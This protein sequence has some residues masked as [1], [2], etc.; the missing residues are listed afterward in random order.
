MS[1]GVGSKLGPYEILSLAGA[2]GMGEVYRA[3]DSRL[4]RTVAVKILPEDVAGDKDR[5]RRF[6]QE[7]RA[8]AALNHPN[9]LSIHDTGALDGTRYIV[10]ELL[11]GETLRERLAGGPLPVRKAV[12]YALQICRGLAA[13][14]EKGITHRDLKPENV[15]ITRDG[16]VKILDFGLAKQETAAAAAATAMH[17]APVDTSPGTVVGT[18]GYMSPEQV[19]GRPVDQ[20][21]DIFAFGAVMYEM[22]SGKRAFRGDTPA[23]TMSAILK[24]EPPDLT[25]TNRNLPPG[26]ERIVRHCLEKNPE[27]R[28]Q[29]AHDI[30]F[31]LDALTGVSSASGAAAKL[32]FGPRLRLRTLAA[33]VAVV[34]AVALIV[35][36]LLRPSPTPPPQFRPITFRLGWM[37]DAR[38]TPDGDIVYSA[39]WD[40]GPQE[41]YVARQGSPG[42]RALGIRDAAVL[43]V[44]STGEMAIATN[45]TS[46]GWGYARAGILALVP[47]TGGSPRPVLDNVEY[48]DFSPD[49]KQMAVVRYSPQTGR[50][51]LEYP[52]GK[53]VYDTSGWLSHP[54]ISPDGSKI[55]FLDHPPPQGDDRGDVALLDREGKKR[56]LSS[57]WSSVQGVVWHGD[58]LWFTGVRNGARRQLYAIGRDGKERALLSAPS[59]LLLEDI[60]GKGELLAKA[61]NQR[62]GVPGLGPGATKERELAWF[63]WSIVNDISADGKTVLLSEEGEAAGTNYLVYVRNTDGSPAVRLGEG[64]GLRISPDGKWVIA[65]L[66]GAGQPLR[67]IPTGTGEARDISHSKLEHDAPSWFPDGKRVLFVGIEAGHGPRDYILDVETGKEQP[68]TPEGTRG[69]V[70][71]PDGKFVVVADTHN[72]QHIWSLEKGESQ[73][74][75]GLEENERAFAWTGDGKELYVT[76]TGGVGVLPRRV[77]LLEPISGRRRPWRTLAPADLTGVTNISFPVISPDGRTYGYTYN[78]KIGDLFVI[79]GVK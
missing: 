75:K 23:D 72:E 26:L 76:P 67:L 28:F 61:E 14:H 39:A 73:P 44:S 46:L 50:W 74:I 21:T 5:L 40:G 70:L 59:N 10:T 52:V 18:A 38:F 19:R 27:E 17:S 6:D 32:D 22:I 65:Q 69:T 2:G 63:D 36:I 57:G 20:R 48:A 1:I 9:I 77:S 16:R 31:A 35:A 41:I 8:I 62:H 11:E 13:A 51:R 56:V 15:Y 78:R 47:L 29:S 3:R 54:R 25:E 53:V 34:L 79:R 68:L 7:A 60:N 64:S 42:D 55:A 37:G 45:M 71:S 24:E 4:D 30:A 43:A 58:E 66:P 49:G 12:E 33:V